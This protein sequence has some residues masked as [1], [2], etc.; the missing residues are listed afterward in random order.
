MEHFENGTVG[1][2]ISGYIPQ[3]INYSEVTVKLFYKYTTYRPFMIDWSMEYCQAHR[4]GKYNPS[5]AL[6]MKI[7]EE[8]LPE[9]YYPCPH[10]CI[11]TPYKYTHLNYCKMEQ[12]E[13]GTIGLNFSV[14]APQVI[15]YGVITAKVFY[16]YTTY[17]PFMIDWS[18]EYCQAYRTKKYSPST[19]VV[20][21][22]V[23]ESVPYL[24]SPC[25]HG[26][27][28]YNVLWLFE[29][30]YIPET[31]PSGDYRLD[32][33]IRDST[34]TVMFALQVFGSVR[35]QGLIG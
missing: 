24:Y 21:N 3:V 13:N 19:A 27:R 11:E 32:I 31:L 18:M 7:V 34:N 15:N 12:F 25:P 30:R 23:Q 29:P 20:M 6:V 33:Y 1:L 26:N 10:G 9:L 5:T 2:N 8:S 28:T 14:Y 4:V 16:K 17:R 22:I 35:K